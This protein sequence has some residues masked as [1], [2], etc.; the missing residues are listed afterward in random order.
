VDCGRITY[1]QANAILADGYCFRMAI[2][3]DHLPPTRTVHP[4]SRGISGSYRI[5]KDFFR[6]F[7]GRKVKEFF[8]SAIE[9]WVP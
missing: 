2:G 6:D 3:N 5:A 4:I 9:E 8:L 7:A 1:T